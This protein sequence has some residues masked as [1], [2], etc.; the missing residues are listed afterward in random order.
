[1]IESI[2]N[3]N[4]VDAQILGR[5]LETIKQQP[6]MAKITFKVQTNWNSGDGFKMTSTGKDFQMGGQT[7]ERE[8]AFTVT[9]DYPEVIGGRSDGPTVCEMGMASV[10]SCVSQTIMAYATMMGIQL[11]RIRVET[12][13]DLDMRG[14]TGLSDKV[15]PGAQEFRLKFHLESRTASKEQLEQLYELGKRF[16]PAVDTITNGTTIKMS[17]NT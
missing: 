13:G 5:L 7:V 8:K 2:K 1:M 9:S 16:S 3:S 10:G 11:D 6:E 4:G 15:R 14:L 12:E 17:I